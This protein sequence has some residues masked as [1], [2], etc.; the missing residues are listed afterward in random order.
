MLAVVLAVLFL[1]AAGT[2]GTPLHAVLNGHPGGLMWGI[3]RGT[4]HY[5]PTGGATADNSSKAPPPLTFPGEEGVGSGTALLPIVWEGLE[6]V[7]F[8][9]YSLEHSVDGEKQETITVFY[10]TTYYIATVEMGDSS[11]CFVVTAHLLD[12]TD[13]VVGEGCT[14]TCEF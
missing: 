9:R 10:N 12:N 2:T 11:N 13:L 3:A 1:A 14:S 8:S 5:P 7:A 4:T 6:G